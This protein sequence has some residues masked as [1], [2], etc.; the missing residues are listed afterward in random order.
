[1]LDS[2]TETYLPESE[3]GKEVHRLAGKAQLRFE[4]EAFRYREI[5]EIARENGKKGGRPDAP[6]RTISRR[7]RCVTVQQFP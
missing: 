6:V 3:R 5:R 2:I 1:M 7:G 4:G